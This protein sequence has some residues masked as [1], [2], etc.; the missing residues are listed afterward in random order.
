M[1]LTIQS[2]SFLCFLS[3]ITLKLTAQEKAQPI[4]KNGE[5]QIV[6]AFNT[7]DEWIRHDLWV[8]T[9]FDSDLDGKL[10]RMHVSVTR[11]AQTDTEGLKLP[12]IYVTSPYFA[13]VASNE[14]G[15]FWDVKHEIGATPPPHIHPSVTRTG[16]RPIISNSHIRTWIPRGYI[17]VHSSSPG[18]GLSDGFPTVG[19][20]NES[21][22]PKAVV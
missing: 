15:A 6:D 5:A 19:G 22:A 10:D 9:E 2:L 18:T 3:I 13:G 7:P 8:E 20:D 21:L 4:F 12:V 14:D 1:K 11:P 16:K 17:V